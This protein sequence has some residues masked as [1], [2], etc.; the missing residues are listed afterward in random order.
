MAIKRMNLL[1]GG[2]CI[3]VTLMQ[4]CYAGPEQMCGRGNKQE[5]YDFKP[6]E[7]S[8]VALA[9]CE[10]PQDKKCLNIKRD[11]KELEEFYAALEQLNRLDNELVWQSWRLKN[12]K[13]DI[14]DSFK[15]LLNLVERYVT[16]HN[17]LRSPYFK[18]LPFCNNIPR[19]DI[20][21]I[22]KIIDDNHSDFIDQYFA[23]LF[24]NPDKY[25]PLKDF[26]CERMAQKI[27]KLKDDKDKE[28]IH[29]QREKEVVLQK[30]IE[31][32][33]EKWKKINMDKVAD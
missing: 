1:Y 28:V 9:Q 21:E 8:V 5:S 19:S 26:L 10:N 16:I 31:S 12:G 27:K 13:G 30:Q 18:A 7:K 6:I 2:L 17:P 3:V 24:K 11:L 23:L 29:S 33:R 22:I 32:A 15:Y 20:S 4:A 14:S 25:I